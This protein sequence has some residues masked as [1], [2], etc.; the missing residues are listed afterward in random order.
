MKKTIQK[1]LYDLEYTEALNRENTF[2]I[3]IATF[4]IGFVLSSFPLNQKVEVI[5]IS[6]I[7]ILLVYYLYK[8]KL[9]LIKEKISNL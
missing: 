9:D 8:K 3:I 5:F 2:V 1:N 6:I 4:V 7:L